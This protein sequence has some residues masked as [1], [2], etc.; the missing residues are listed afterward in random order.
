MCCSKVLVPCAIAAL[1]SC[2]SAGLLDFS[3]V[4]HGEIITNQFSASHG[5]TISAVNFNRTHDLAIAFDSNE[6]GTADDDLESPFTGG[7][8][9]S[10]TNLGNLL[11][12]STNDTDSNNDNILDSP[13]DEGARPAGELI[14]D[15]AIA[16]TEIGFDLVDV[17]NVTAENGLVEF[18]LG[19]SQVGDTVSFADFTD[20]S[21]DYFRAGV[22][23]GNNSANHITPLTAGEVGFT[24]FDRVVVTMGGSGGIDNLV[25]VPT[26]GT[27]ALVAGAALI[28]VRR[29]RH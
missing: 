1:A 19:G 27:G 21:S 16:Q 2:A 24:E 15:F 7:N 17:E 8:L 20:N 3:G 26:P 6:T 13:N 25:Y 10:T 12:I 11:I 18:Y 9:P 28:G 23:Y 14:F 5:V 29:R 4:Q 22:A